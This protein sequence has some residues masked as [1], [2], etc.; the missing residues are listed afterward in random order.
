MTLRN[1]QSTATT[2]KAMRRNVSQLGSDVITLVELQTELLQVDL[3]EWATGFVRSVV[4]MIAALVLLL[5]ST[6]VLL[7]SVG[8][9]ISQASDLS[10]GVSMLIAA[11][12]GI[13]VAAVFAGL[14]VWMLRREQGMLHR[15]R[16]ELKHNITWLKH[17][18][19]SPA[20]TTAARPTYSSAQPVS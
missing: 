14:G 13:L 1:G 15:F 6:P 18:L 11:G 9:F 16:R 4:A 5:A 10:L 3:R 17:V 7:I 19:S 20:E 12:I 2:V 8:Y